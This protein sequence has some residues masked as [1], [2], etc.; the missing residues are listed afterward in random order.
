[1]RR[2]SHRSIRTHQRRSNIPGNGRFGCV[3]L[4][5]HVVSLVEVWVA[6]VDGHVRAGPEEGCCFVFLPHGGDPDLRR[7]RERGEKE[8]RQK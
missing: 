4:N 3:D 2:E 1:M 6:A 5:S 8:E 7:R